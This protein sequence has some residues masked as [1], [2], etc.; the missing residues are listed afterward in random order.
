[1]RPVCLV[2][3][4]L[5]PALSGAQQEDWEEWDDDAWEE[6][7]AAGVE[8]HG[9][10]EGAYGTRWNDDPQVGRRRTLGDARVRLETDWANDAVTIEL[11]GEVWYD[12]VSEDIEGELRDLTLAF[13]PTSNL[14]LK[15]GRQVLTWGTGDLLFLND[16]FPKDW[17]SFFAGRED[18]YLK[19]PSNAVRGTWYSKALNVD[20]VWTPVFE[21]DNYLTGERFSFFS[22]LAGMLVAPQPP[23]DGIEPARTVDNGE[24][25]V[26]LFKNVRGTEYAA[27][28]H[29]GFFKQP[30]D[31]TEQLMPR[32]APLSALGAS[33]RRPLW[34]G[35]FN[36]EAV[37]YASRDD[38]SGTNPALPND[39]LRFL[40]GF[41]REAVTNFTVGFQY[42][43]EWTLDHDELIGDSPMPEFEP[44]EFRHVV[45]NRLTYRM[46]QDKLTLSLFTF[47]SPSDDDY[48][49][50]PVVSYRYSDRWSMT[51]GA[52]VFGGEDDHTFFGQFQDNS[53]V[54]FR[55]RFNY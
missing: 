27:Y 9:F 39:Q 47:Y 3:L 45:T 55:V 31:F 20:M 32:F 14:D 24:F 17:V 29:R 28:A 6:E 21:P 2:F 34:S 36:A 26:R 50:R 35:L 46:S 51:G 18:E 38:R 19:A 4:M 53:N 16:L 7:A 54:Y 13:S 25:S 5:A 15:L 11:K 41:E 8:W 12:N 33:M 37:Y 43:V 10:V 22:P 44:D 1:M 30:T 40:A 52:N 23:F 49:L 48:F 42:Y